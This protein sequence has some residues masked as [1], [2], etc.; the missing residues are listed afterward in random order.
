MT[1]FVNAIKIESYIFV[2]K[3]IEKKQKREN[4]T[5]SKVWSNVLVHQIKS[6]KKIEIN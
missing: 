1:S 4:I 3:K 6:E 2:K 5:Q